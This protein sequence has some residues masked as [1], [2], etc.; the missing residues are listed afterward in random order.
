[1]AEDSQ[2]GHEWGFFFKYKIGTKVLEKH[3]VG[4]KNNRLNQNAFFQKG[5]TLK[6]GN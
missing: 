5:K 4:G 3:S 6:F 2:I 1:M